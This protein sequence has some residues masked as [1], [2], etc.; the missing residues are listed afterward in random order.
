MKIYKKRFI[1]TYVP[2]LLIFIN[3]FSQLDDAV[4]FHRMN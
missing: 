2:T 1:V 3:I 4:S